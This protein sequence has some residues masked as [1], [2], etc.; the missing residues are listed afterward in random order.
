MTYLKAFNSIPHDLI[1]AKLEA[2]GLEIDALT[3][4]HNTHLINRKQG[5]KV[6]EAYSS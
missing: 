2:Y 3:L 6:K 5:A 4:I 1:T